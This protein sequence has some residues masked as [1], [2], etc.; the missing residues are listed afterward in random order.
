MSKSASVVRAGV[1]VAK[2]GARVT[3][4]DV[5]TNVLHTLRRTMHL[6]A[7][8]SGAHALAQHRL[9]GGAG[10]VAANGEA[11]SLAFSDADT[12]SSEGHLLEAS[13]CST[14]APDGVGRTNDVAWEV[15][16]MRIC[17]M[18]W[19]CECDLLAS[20]APTRTPS[21]F[22][23]SE[24]AGAQER[25]DETTSALD[26]L[27]LLHGSAAPAGGAPRE[28]TFDEPSTSADLPP[29][30]AADTTFS[31]IVGCEVL[32]E[33]VHAKWLAAALKRRLAHGGQ[34]FITG[35]IRDAAVRTTL[36]TWAAH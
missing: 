11:E 9:E 13:D 16:N 19:K 28:S 35:A 7:T 6:N 3:M 22:A 10:A 27:D 2:L 4:T 18:D 31:V 14:G 24:A 8:P 15:A 25:V 5:V 17:F 26:A 21:D 30:V 36:A 20:A 23:A 32:Y 34:A 33:M 29:K 1:T 12:V